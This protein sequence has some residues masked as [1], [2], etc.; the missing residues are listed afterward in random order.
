MDRGAIL[1]AFGWQGNS[2]FLDERVRQAISMGIDRDLYL[3]TFHSVRQL[4]ADGLPVETRWN[5][6]M[7]GIEKNEGFWLDPKEKE[8]G[9]NAKYY[10]H[11]IA[12]AKKLLAAAGHASG[13]EISAK[14][15]TGGELPNIPLRAEVLNGM[16]GDI[17]I[18]TTA[19]SLNYT[20][21]YLPKY[22]DGNGQWEGILY[23]G[24]GGG[25]GSG[26]PVGELSNWW[27]S[28]GGPTFFG[29]STSG[30]NDLA[31]D[32]EVD[33]MIEKARVERSTE[34]R[35]S[36]AFDIQRQIAKRAYGFLT[37]G[38]ATGFLM[39]WPALQNFR[40]YQGARANYRVWVDST[41][42]PGA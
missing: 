9:V 37:P 38:V 41:Q 10:K 31:G 40:V 8:F 2:P 14:L 35:R 34:R 42:P 36:L 22:R 4:Q 15:V 20:Q 24:G 7:E 32:P 18:R 23:K 11:D 12:E 26:D 1:M 29:F 13:F 25:I 28:K 17:G 16:A 19:T 27:W 39:A 6:A 5:T 30:K 3:D 33:A 21:E